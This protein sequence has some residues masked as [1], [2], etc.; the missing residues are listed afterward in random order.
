MPPPSESGE[1]YTIRQKIFAILGA[2]FQVY[3][4]Q[5]ELVAFC[6]QKAFKLKEDI[7]VYTD[8]SKETE[9]FSMKARSII[10]F[11]AT[12]DI[13]L[14]DGQ[15]LASIRR[16]GLKSLLRD[17]WM[18]FNADGEQIAQLQEDSAGMAFMRRLL[19]IIAVISP[20]RFHLEPVQ[21]GQPTGFPIAT[22]RTHFNL[23]VYRLGVTVHQDDEDLDDLVILA[24]GCLIA[25]IEG[26]QSNENSGS[27]LFSGG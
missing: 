15:I 8:E 27:G 19:P 24:M 22:F 17:S 5:G 12:Y 13:A 6:R 2:S 23:F 11:G 9:L 1:R 10:D 4:E 3:G 25:A 14:P 21:G 26:R 18:V 20:Q 7:R 16:K